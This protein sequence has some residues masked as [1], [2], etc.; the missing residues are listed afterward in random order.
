M[1]Y[2]DPNKEN[3]NFLQNA[4]SSYK[5]K[6]Y[7]DWQYIANQQVANPDLSGLRRQAYQGRD[8]ALGRL[9]SN[10]G[11]SRTKLKNSY[12][13]AMSNLQSS[14]TNQTNSAI[15]RSLASGLG[16]MGQGPGVGLANYR[17]DAIKDNFKPSFER[18]DRDNAVNM[19][20]L[21][22]N[23]NEGTDDVYSKY[24]GALG[25]IDEQKEDRNLKVAA[26]ATRLMQQD[27]QGFRNWQEALADTLRKYSA[28]QEDM[29]Y[30]QEQDAYKREQDAF[31]NRL[32]LERFGWSKE[33]AMF[34]YQYPTANSLLSA[35]NNPGGFSPYQ[36]YQ[37]QNRQVTQDFISQ[38]LMSPNKE[39]FL[40]EN[41][42]D[43]SESGVDLGTVWSV[44][45]N[46]GF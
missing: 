27:T 4:L 40:Q 46:Y 12:S 21:L 28:D 31:N 5:P 34:P 18:L 41:I 14:Q 22:R 8:T 39:Q 29:A 32:A 2:Y 30:K 15:K 16:G 37:M 10:Y 25:K 26:E 36:Q 7:N 13:D 42:A 3:Q 9:K 44:Y 11:D 33:Q 19:K 23:Y 35:Q 43:A 1:A 6:Q 45:N 24:R 17:T 38:L 20:I